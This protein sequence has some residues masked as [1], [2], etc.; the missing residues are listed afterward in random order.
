MRT[1]RLLVAVTFSA[2]GRG[3]F[4]L[5]L[6]E[7]TMTFSLTGAETIPIPDDLV[8][9]DACEPDQHVFAAGLL[10]FLNIGRKPDREE[11]EADMERIHGLLVTLIDSALPEQ[12]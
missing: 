11:L 1:S 6:D 5:E 7:A 4:H 3:E 9:W 8:E 10:E 12:D 2:G